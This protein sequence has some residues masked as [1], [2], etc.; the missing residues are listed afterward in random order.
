MNSAAE[1]KTLAGSPYSQRAITWCCGFYLFCY[2]PSQTSTPLKGLKME[3][4]ADRRRFVCL[5]FS[6]LNRASQSSA[7][8]AWVLGGNK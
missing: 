7:M 1:A 3:P 8:P 2:E 6:Y 4:F 5:Y